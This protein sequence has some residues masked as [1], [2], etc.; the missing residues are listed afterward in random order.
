MQSKLTLRLDESLIRAAKAYAREADKSLSQI[1]ADY[2]SVLA[3]KKGETELD[4][5]SLPPITRSLIGSVKIE[6]VV[7]DDY[8]TYLMEKYR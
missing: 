6:N 4:L 5:N 8:Y 2:F 3:A 7:E 1:V